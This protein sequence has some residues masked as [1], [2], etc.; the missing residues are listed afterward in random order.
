MRIV[1][2]QTQVVPQTVVVIVL[3]LVVLK[4]AEPV[5]AMRVRAV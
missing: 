1:E 3:S 5:V 4:P 2:Q